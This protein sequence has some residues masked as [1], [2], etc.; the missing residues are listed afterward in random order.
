MNKRLTVKELKKL[1]KDN[2]IPNLSKLRRNGVITLLLN[3]NIDL[4]GKEK[5]IN[6]K[7]LSKQELVTICDIY[8]LKYGE[9]TKKSLIKIIKKKN[10]VIPINTY[11]NVDTTLKSFEL[12]IGV[13]EHM[14]QKFNIYDNII[15]IINEFIH[16]NKPYD[17]DH[18]E[19][20]NINYVEKNITS[21]IHNY[22]DG[23]EY[24]NINNFIGSYDYSITECFMNTDNRNRTEL[25]RLLERREYDIISKI[26]GTNNN[27]LLTKQGGNKS[28]LY[29]LCKNGETAAIQLFPNLTTDH[30]RNIGVKNKTGIYYLCKNGMDIVLNKLE[31]LTREDFLIVDEQ[32]TPLSYLCGMTK[33]S[34][35]LINL[36][37]KYED[38]IRFAE[39]IIRY[40]PENVTLHYKF[41]FEDVFVDNFNLNVMVKVLCK[42]KY[43]RVLLRYMQNL[44]LNSFITNNLY[45]GNYKTNLYILCKNK[46]EDVITQIQGLT[47]EHFAVALIRGK[48]PLLPVLCEQKLTKVFNLF[49]KI[50]AEDIIKVTTAQRTGLYWLCRNK[51]VNIIKKIN[52]LELG[53]FLIEEP[54]RQQTALYWLNMYEI[55]VTI[56]L[57]NKDIIEKIN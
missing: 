34:D 9:T 39:S 8:K 28:L 52:G 21:T 29:N 19:V 42:R 17:S 2:K 37:F 14:K 15:K 49:D 30:Y 7:H 33:I 24:N 18:K 31:G 26:K 54:K 11:Y 4:F 23:Y 57:D 32:D 35:L 25:H 40:Q 51:M 46:M 16:I 36:N 53:H 1:A 22:I 6:Y 55:D 13:V 3:K 41:K 50:E 12:T 5:Y 38:I 20:E 45:Y 43:S 48:Y 10:I 44:E 56:F 27:C 47:Y